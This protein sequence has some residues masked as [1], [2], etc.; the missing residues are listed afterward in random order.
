MRS[1]SH[2]FRSI[3]HSAAAL[4]ALGGALRC[5]DAAVS[6]T[7]LGV[8]P[9]K[10]ESYAYGL[11]PGAT[12]V[13]GESHVTGSSEAFRWTPATGMVGLGDLSGGS[14]NSLAYAASSNGSVIV[15]RGTTAAGREA[16]RWT[17][18]TGMVSLGDFAGGPVESFATD[19]NADGSVV[20]GRGA[21]AVGD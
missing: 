11:S 6:I 13:V 15:G 21:T 4:L 20:V 18:G 16:Y 9:G 2:P 7:A 14:I 3:V 8:L 19:V 5:A 12:V 10:P 17:S 1:L